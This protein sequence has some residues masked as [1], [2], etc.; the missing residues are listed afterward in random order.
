LGH[1]VHMTII[2]CLSKSS[3]SLGDEKKLSTSTVFFDR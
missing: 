2:L 3:K 1:T